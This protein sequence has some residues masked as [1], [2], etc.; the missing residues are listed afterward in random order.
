[1]M[2]LYLRNSGG[3]APFG[4]AQGRLS[5]P[6]PPGKNKIASAAEVRDRRRGPEETVSQPVPPLRGCCDRLLIDRQNS[7]PLATQSLKARSTRTQQFWN[8]F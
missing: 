2:L 5:A 4:C 3:A 1:M 7:F 6:R 8:Q